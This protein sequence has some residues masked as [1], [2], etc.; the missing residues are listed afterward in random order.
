MLPLL[1]LSTSAIIS[2][3]V[4]TVLSAAR[5][6][7]SALERNDGNDSNWRREHF[8]IG[9]ICVLAGNIAIFCILS[10]LCR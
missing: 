9:R 10:A 7:H 4:V 8:P 1:L 6:W 5:L 2:V 3:T